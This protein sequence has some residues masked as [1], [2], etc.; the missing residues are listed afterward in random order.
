MSFFLSFLYCCYFFVTAALL[1]FVLLILY[2]FV[3]LFDRQKGLLH[4]LTS[5]WGYH[6]V[7]LNPFWNCRF[8]GMHYLIPG[9]NYVIV[10][11]HQSL[12]DIFVLSGL[13]HHFKW[14]SKESLLRIPFFGWNMKLNE[15]VAIKR[16]DK[17]SIR[18]MMSSCKKWLNQ[19]VSIMMF[20]EGTRSDDG[21][22]GAFRDGS[23][24]LSQDCN[25]PMLPIVISGTREIVAKHSRI[26]NFGAKISITILPP[27]L[28]EFFSGKPGLMKKHVH[29][30]MERALLRK[31]PI[32]IGS[33]Q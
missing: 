23:F 28:P 11:N 12:A 19:G 30:M 26:F 9:Q 15:Y 16:G 4:T 27:V 20:P 6:F 1:F 24:R 3:I 33:A 17:K 8:E 31:C 13:R 2:P 32:E 22:I 18:E 29:E 25:V 21:K 7:L 14:V 10:A 5:L